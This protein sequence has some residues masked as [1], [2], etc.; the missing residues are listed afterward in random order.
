MI[1]LGLG[2]TRAAN[3]GSWWL[4][5]AA[6][7]ADFYRYR[8]ML[9]GATVSPK[10]LITTTHATTGYAER[11]DDTFQLFQPN[12]PRITD[13]GLLFENAATNL[14][15]KSNTFDQWTA[16]NMTVT[17]N[18]VLGP[19]GEMDADTL[20]SA[21]SGAPLQLYNSAAVSS[22]TAYTYSVFVKAG[23]ATTAEIRE[24]T[25]GSAVFDLAA[26]TVTSG[27]GEIKV[28]ANGWYRLSVEYTTGASQT[29]WTGKVLFTAGDW[30]KTLHVA[31]AQLEA[32]TRATSYIPTT[33]T[34]ATRAADD[35]KMVPSGSLPFPGF[36]VSEGT[37]LVDWY[38]EEIGGIQTAFSLNDG[39]AL[40]FI[41]AGAK[42]GGSVDADVEMWARNA[43][44]TQAFLTHIGGYVAGQRCRQAVAWKANDFVSSL[45]GGA[46]LTDTTAALPTLTTLQ[47]GAAGASIVSSFTSI[48]SYMRSIAYFPTR[49]SNAD[50][51]AL[52]FAE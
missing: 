39:T 49:M 52:K 22:S 46:P 12:E 33:T 17:A 30:S 31:A 27:T 25:L 47:L 24:T 37:M 20:T 14:M 44:G 21:A 4:P 6:M 43:S 11:S 41:N 3:A 5:G 36:N 7:Q 23:T 10:Q 26:G 38:V 42:V 19:F 50:L 35:I 29:T 32:G 15:P 9:L 18:A 28:Y 34:A 2:V 51:Q 16:V 48:N 8:A 1:G 13:K 45:N 40:E